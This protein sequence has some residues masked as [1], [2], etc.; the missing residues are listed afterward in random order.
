MSGNSNFQIA[1]A[2]NLDA[3][4]AIQVIWGSAV[5]VFNFFSKT[6]MQP[7]AVPYAANCS[8][9]GGESEGWKLTLQSLHLRSTTGTT[10]GTLRIGYSGSNFLPDLLTTKFGPRWL[11]ILAALVVAT[12]EHQG[13]RELHDL[14]QAT[15]ST[16][17]GQ[18]LLDEEQTEK[19]WLMGRELFLGS[20]VQQEFQSILSRCQTSSKAS[21]PAAA[22]P[23]S[24]TEY[25]TPMMSA[26]FRAWEMSG[27]ANKDKRQ[28]ADGK[29]QLRG[30]NGF[31]QLILYLAA[32]CG[33]RVTVRLDQGDIEFGDDKSPTNVTV[34]LD[35]ELGSMWQTGYLMDSHSVEESVQ[36]WLG[37]SQEFGLALWKPGTTAFVPIHPGRY[38]CTSEAV[39]AGTNINLVGLTLRK[40]QLQEA[41]I[42]KYVSMWL[43]NYL[44][45]ILRNTQLL[46]THRSPGLAQPLS[47]K[48]I[49][50]P[51]RDH[52]MAG[53]LR[54]ALAVFNPELIISE[55]VNLLLK[56][57][58]DNESP[59]P[60]NFLVK[61]LPKEQSKLFCDCESHGP[62]GMTCRFLHISREL[63]E[64]AWKIWICAHLDI[65]SHALLR[66]VGPVAE[67][68]VMNQLGMM[69][70]AY[71][72]IPAIISTGVLLSCAATRL[73][74][75]LFNLSEQNLMGLAAGG[76]VLGLKSN[77]DKPV[78]TDPG[79]CLYIVPGSIE[80]PKRRVREIYQSPLASS[81]IGRWGNA[82]ELDDIRCP[83]DRF[84]PCQMEHTVEILGDR[85]TIQ[86]SVRV[87]EKSMGVDILKAIDSA[88]TIRLWE[89]CLGECAQ[90]RLAEAE[91][92][93]VQ[94]T[95]ASNYGMLAQTAGPRQKQLPK[96][97]VV[98]AYNNPAIERAVVS[99]QSGKCFCMIQRGDCT[100]CAVRA[101][102]IEG[103]TVLLD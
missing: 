19:M 52:A 42:E 36:H 1:A 28:Y 46:N 65:K 81:G 102:L 94:V 68:N 87:G 26:C 63:E 13:A 47:A 90:G 97:K 73:A 91:M 7:S 78:L 43:M 88:S 56:R 18:Y 10:I 62:F 49:R 72:M 92:R 30:W 69:S 9:V 23:P 71:E 67:W 61:S 29:I 20:P 79:H 8:T 40:Q 39:E 15:A 100:H 95:D 11:G 25:F 16:M 98:L 45:A 22:Y 64:F 53:R 99:H 54:I 24:S 93:Q 5:G 35:K 82:L 6:S 21:L 37:A 75:R 66:D 38:T 4:Q 77:E 59:G 14:L 83:L 58:A 17:T 33:F 85:A 12:T 80:T 48:D 89:G 41:G 101:A 74:G 96:L 76:A 31:G 27:V 51:F 103:A 44:H 84:G 86:T 32:V 60:L 34:I 57:I 55:H 3:L 70:G 50:T 2:V